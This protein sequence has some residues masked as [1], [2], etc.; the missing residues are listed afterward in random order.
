M[1][2]TLL[3]FSVLASQDCVVSAESFEI[4]SF[5]IVFLQCREEEVN[6][7]I[8][9]KSEFCTVNKWAE[10]LEVIRKYNFPLEEN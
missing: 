10:S 5:F 3:A 9:Y 8:D 6:S 1:N 2:Y 4:S 7:F